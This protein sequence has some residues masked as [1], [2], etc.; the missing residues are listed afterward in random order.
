MS[1][2]EENNKA[3]VR[4]FLE[5]QTKC[6]LA[7]MDEKNATLARNMTIERPANVQASQ[8]TVRVRILLIPRLCSRAPSVTTPLYSTTVSLT[9]R[10]TL[11]G[12]G[13]NNIDPHHQP[14]AHG[15]PEDVEVGIHVCSP[16]S[17]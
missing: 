2:V 8:A 12:N 16:N 10:L 6:D 13:L 17:V 15:G 5:A 7:A 4:P 3:L 11:R 9:L 14:Q 1:S